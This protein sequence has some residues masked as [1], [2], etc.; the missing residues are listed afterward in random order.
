MR[1]RTS[2]IFTNAPLKYVLHFEVPVE[3]QW[4]AYVEASAG[5]DMTREGYWRWRR[6]IARLGGYAR[7]VEWETSWRGVTGQGIPGAAK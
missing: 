1:R 3:L 2:E 7:D 6:T 4:A 5:I